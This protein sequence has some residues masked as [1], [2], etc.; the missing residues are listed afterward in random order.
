M[1]ALTVGGVGVQAGMLEQ[2]AGSGIVVC[3]YPGGFRPC[4]LLHQSHLF[5]WQHWREPSP[6]GPRCVWAELVAVWT[7]LV[8]VFLPLVGVSAALSLEGVIQGNSLELS[9][10]WWA[11]LGEEPGLEK[12]KTTCLPHIQA[13]RVSRYNHHRC[14]S[15]LQNMMLSVVLSGVLRWHSAPWPPAPVLRASCCCS[16]VSQPAMALAACLHFLSSGGNIS[17][18]HLALIRKQMWKMVGSTAGCANP[19]VLQG[20]GC[21]CSHCFTL[22]KRVVIPVQEGHSFVLTQWQHSGSVPP[23]RVV[24][25]RRALNPCRGNSQLSGK[26]NIDST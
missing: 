17:C 20:Y 16:W 18:E 5:S 23:D 13:H 15:I 25:P 24:F 12:A 4:L 2:L 9:Q 21:H 14:F 1:K 19:E 10:G 7:C 26:D 8:G 11:G 3:Y 6:E 22:W